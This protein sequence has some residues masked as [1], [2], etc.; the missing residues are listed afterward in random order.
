M[1]PLK[2]RKLHIAWVAAAERRLVA[3]AL[4]NGGFSNRH[5]AQLLEVSPTTVSKDLS[6]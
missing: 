2:P 5:I 3:R 6:T 4:K 1:P